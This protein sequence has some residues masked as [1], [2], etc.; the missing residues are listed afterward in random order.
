MVRTLE[1]ENR[2]TY[3]YRSSSED[4]VTP[5]KE[6]TS[7][8]HSPL[9]PP[10][11]ES[12]VNGTFPPLSK[13]PPRKT[14]SLSPSKPGEDHSPLRH[15]TSDSSHLPKLLR[16]SSY[17]SRRMGLCGP[18]QVSIERCTFPGPE[19]VMLPD[20]SEVRRLKSPWSDRHQKENKPRPL[21]MDDEDKEP[22]LEKDL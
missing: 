11:S 22:V 1:T 16:T 10:T 5:H 20:S 15:P 8:H 6:T 19:G 9:F 2:S 17:P 21:N 12:T 14:D 18:A 13:R 7:K 4:E 3:S